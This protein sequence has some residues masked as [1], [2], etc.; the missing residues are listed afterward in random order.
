MYHLQVQTKAILRSMEPWRQQPRRL[1]HQ[2]A[3]NKAPPEHAAVLCLRSPPTIYSSD[4]LTRSKETRSS[5]WVLYYLNIIK[6][7]KMKGI[8]NI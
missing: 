6:N 7:I 4:R 5:L 2:E 8:I 1:L 3:L